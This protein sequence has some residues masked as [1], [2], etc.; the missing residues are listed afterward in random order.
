MA[1]VIDSRS[2]RSPNFNDR[3]LGARIDAIVCHTTEGYWHT[4]I[5]YLCSPSS[6]VSCHYVI[7]PDGTIYS[8]VDD[9]K[10]AWH[11]GESSYAGRVNWND[12]SIGI[13]VSHVQNQPYDARVLP[14]LTALCK[15]LISI[16]PIQ[17]SYIV[18]HRYVAPT[19]RSDMTNVSD[20]QFENWATSLF[21]A[22]SRRYQVTSPCAIFTDRRVDAPLS[23]GPD[24]GQTQTWLDVGDVINVGQIQDGW[25]WVSDSETTPPGIG[26]LPSSYAR[27][28]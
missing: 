7:A 5:D 3:P 15:Q 17:R 20:A 23:D 2:Y 26:F 21:V 11:A 25:L 12:F 18:Q 28:L 14:S 27:P 1:L 4:D 10:R 19:R 6:G 24:G 16:H 22:A 13:E 9:Q 8:I